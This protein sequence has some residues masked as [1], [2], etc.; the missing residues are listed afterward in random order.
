VT[1][2]GREQREAGR[3]W[4]QSFDKIVED[5]ALPDPGALS[6]ALATAGF[7]RRVRL[8]LAP[9]GEWAEQEADRLDELNDT[10]WKTVDLL[11]WSQPRLARQLAGIPT[12]GF[13]ERYAE[14]RAQEDALDDLI[15]RLVEVARVAAKVP[16][17]RRG[18]GQRRVHLAHGNRRVIE[19]EYA[20]LR[21][22]MDVLVS[23]WTLDLGR[24]FRQNHYAWEGDRPKPSA[25]EGLRFAFACVEL[26]AP[27]QGKALKTIARE[28][29]RYGK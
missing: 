28:Y 19:A 15:D 12:E 21:A 17:L 5:F 3:R 1:A 22:A 11:D 25:P 4:K 26:I 20:P 10:L 27:G 23:Y 7:T 29:T 8:L 2:P 18:R 13:G 6:D 24:R 16:R 9:G 14:F